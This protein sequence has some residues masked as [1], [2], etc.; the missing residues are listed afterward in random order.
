MTSLESEIL[1]KLYSSGIKS[2]IKI[3]FWE[4]APFVSKSKII[5]F[6]NVCWMKQLH[7][8]L[9]SYDFYKNLLKNVFILFGKLFWILRIVANTL[10]FCVNAPST[11]RSSKKLATNDIKTVVTGFFFFIKIICRT[12]SSALLPPFLSHSWCELWSIFLKFN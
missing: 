1:S 3:Q 12:L 2:K 5:F 10:L 7:F 8:L 6:L 4:A 11:F 9:M